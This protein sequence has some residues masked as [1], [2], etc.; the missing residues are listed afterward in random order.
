METLILMYMFITIIVYINYVNVKSLSIDNNLF[1]N[2]WS[3]LLYMTSFA[4]PFKYLLK[5]D[6]ELKNKEKAIE[7]KLYK[8]NL[9]NYFNLRSFLTLR[10]IILLLS[11]LS[12]YTLIQLIKLFNHDFSILQNVPLI[13]P[14]LFVPLIPDMYLKSTEKRCKSFYYDEVAILQLFMISLIETNSTIEEI[15]FAFSKM[16]TFHK[17]TF[18]KAYRMSLRNK[19]EALEFLED[20]FNDVVFGSSFNILNNM[21]EYSKYASLRILKSNLKTL[22]EDS[23][24]KRR[25]E[26]LGK[27]SF[28]QVSMVVPFLIA[29]LLGALP[30]IYFGTNNIMSIMKDL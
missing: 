23:V 20:K 25:K 18:E 2:K 22:E 26:E 28:A 13:I 1:D 21:V 12:F 17:K 30:L 27:F 3:N 5:E 7:E 9:N 15:L 10:F 19:K 8:L 24:N 29:V 16:N 14:F 4:F 6:R 11:L